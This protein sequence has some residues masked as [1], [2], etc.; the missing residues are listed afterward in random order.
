MS[1][2]GASIVPAAVGLLALAV[3]GRSQEMPKPGPEHQAMGIFLG[4]W[5]FDGEAEEGLMGPGGKVT[6]TESCEW[7][8][9]GFALVCRTEG[10]NPMGPTRSL[11]IMSYDA[12]K[13]TYTYYAV[14]SG[15]PPFLATGQHEGKAW[16][17]HTE[18]SMGGQTM[19]T[20][21]T[22]TE[23]SPTATT[24]EMKASMDGGKTW[25]PVMQGKS[26]KTSS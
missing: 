6:F 23:V 19:K 4:K 25:A 11:S 24:L 17:W 7:F 5:S 22:I 10:K 18:S 9:G 1:S 13:K 26:T 15:F 2:I 16:R 20:E 8:E 12:E 14:E 21:V 3:S